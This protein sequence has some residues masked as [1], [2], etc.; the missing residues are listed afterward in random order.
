MYSPT[1]YAKLRGRIIEKYSSQQSFSEAIGLSE[2]SIT[3]KMQGKSG[4][5]QRDIVKWCQALDIDL[6]DV[7]IYFF[8]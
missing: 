4:F 8:A 5:S 1:K 7:G 3:K 2:V 6:A